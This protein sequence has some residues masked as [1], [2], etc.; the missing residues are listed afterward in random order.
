[1]PTVI[2]GISCEEED[3]SIVSNETNGVINWKL[4]TYELK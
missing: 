3:I 2:G 1:M 4:K